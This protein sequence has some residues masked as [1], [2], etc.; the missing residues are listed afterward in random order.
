MPRQRNSMSALLDEETAGD[1]CVCGDQDQTLNAVTVTA[2]LDTAVVQLQLELLCIKT[3]S[4]FIVMKPREHTVSSLTQSVFMQSTHSNA[5]IM[6]QLLIFATMEGQPGALR[7]GG[8]C[9]MPRLPSGCWDNARGKCVRRGG[10]QLWL[11]LL[12]A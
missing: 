7:M 8:G 2:E 1:G 10:A 9:I 4:V 11:Q 6:D 12:G 3:A 5:F